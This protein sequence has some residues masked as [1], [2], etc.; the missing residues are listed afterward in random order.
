MTE[1]SAET[2]TLLLDV[3]VVGTDDDDAVMAVPNVRGAEVILD[4]VGLVLILVLG[5][6][7]L[8]LLKADT[9]SASDV[10]SGATL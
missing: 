8:E 4:V 1:T 5:I 7:V 6:G 3:K 9:P 10:A 2:K